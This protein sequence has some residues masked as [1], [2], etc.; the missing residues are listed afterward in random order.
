MPQM[1]L[2]SSGRMFKSC[3][4][5]QRTSSSEH[6]LWVTAPLHVPSTGFE[7]N[8]AGA[9]PAL[10]RQNTRLRSAPHRAA[11]TAKA[12]LSG[13]LRASRDEAATCVAETPP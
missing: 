7:L 11:F 13:R 10:V 5:D 4:P 6:I 3:Q 1:T 2:G 9:R 8:C 12:R